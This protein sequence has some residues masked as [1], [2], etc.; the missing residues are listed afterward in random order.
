MKTERVF[1]LRRIRPMFKSWLDP[2]RIWGSGI[3]QSFVGADVIGPLRGLRVSPA[4]GQTRV[5]KSPTTADV[6]VGVIDAIRLAASFFGL[7]FEAFA[8]MSGT[9]LA[10]DLDRAGEA[11][12]DDIV[13]E[14]GLTGRTTGIATLFE[15]GSKQQRPEMIATTQG[16]GQ[17]THAR[18][19]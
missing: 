13:L 10:I 5:F 16:H 14:L 6:I 8:P 12:P 11:P 3:V 17:R 15:V 4:D 2:A 7:M 9:L 18:G 1:N 19:G